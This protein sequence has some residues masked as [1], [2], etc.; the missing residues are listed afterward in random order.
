MRSAPVW[1]R[2]L[3]RRAARVVAAV[4]PLR[5]APKHYGLHVFQRMRLAAIELGRRLARAGVLGGRGRRVLPRA[6]GARVA[7]ARAT[8]GAGD[9]TGTARRAAT[10]HPRRDHRA[11][12]AAARRVPRPRR[13]RLRALRRRAGRRRR[14]ER[15]AGARRRAPRHRRLARRRDRH[16]ARA[17]SPRPA[18]LRA[19]RRAGGGVRRPGM[20]AA[21]S[22]RFGSGD[23]GRRRDVPRRGGRAR[24]RHPRGVRRHARHRAA[25]A[26]PARLGRRLDAAW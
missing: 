26:R 23:G 11:S 14:R 3:L 9:G 17:R 4:L 6:R 15:G 20:D 7:L 8:I 25:G 2:P 16:R 18:R 5:E 12:A 24:A 10:A 1:K 13:A 22:A 21:L 19:G